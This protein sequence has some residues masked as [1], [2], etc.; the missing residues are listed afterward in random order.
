M[1]TPGESYKP[2]GQS[3]AS[4][5]LKLIEIICQEVGGIVLKILKILNASGIPLEK[6]TIQCS[7][8]E[9][10]MKPSDPHNYMCRCKTGTSN[11]P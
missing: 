5:H 10:Y 7:G 3:L 2:T 4:G 1:L 6:I 9:L 11:D 8:R